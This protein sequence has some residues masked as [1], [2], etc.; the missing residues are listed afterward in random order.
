MRKT[1]LIVPLVLLLFAVDPNRAHG[2]KKI[3][4]SEKLLKPAPPPSLAGKLRSPFRPDQ[5]LTEKL[6]SPR[7]T[8][9]TFLFAAITYDMFP[10]MMEDALAC[11]DLE[12]WRM[13]REEGTFLALELDKILA[14]LELP[15]RA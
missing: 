6:R 7:E 9:R 15:L 10:E 2:Q 14:H 12:F 11:L 4:P 5:P 1:H 3:D 13:S 8:M